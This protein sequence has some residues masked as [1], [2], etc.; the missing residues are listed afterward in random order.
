MF[1]V[2][3]QVLG[4]VYHMPHSGTAML[5][6]TDPTLEFD[7]GSLAQ[8]LSDTFTLDAHNRVSFT[9]PNSN[10][11]TL[12][13]TPSSGRFFGSFTDPSTRRGGP[14]EGVVLQKQNIGGGFSSSN[15][16]TGRVFF[17]ET[18]ATAP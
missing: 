5:A 6:L 2:D 15:R 13:L 7:G 11:F 12:A 16:T 9:A 14:Y 4:S 17:G 8:P 10:R 3:T 18:G 1:S